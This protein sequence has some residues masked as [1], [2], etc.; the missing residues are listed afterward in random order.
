[1]SSVRV[2][3]RNCAA[4]ARPRHA[5]SPC[6]T[7]TRPRRWSLTGRWSRPS[8]RPDRARSALRCTIGFAQIRAP[9]VETRTGLLP[10]PR[11]RSALGESGRLAIGGGLLAACGRSRSS[12]SG[13]GS[14]PTSASG[15]LERAVSANA[16]RC[17]LVQSGRSGSLVGADSQAAEIPQRQHCWRRR[18]RLPLRPSRRLL[19]S[20][21]STTWQALRR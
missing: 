16:K 8:T 5:L 11:R 4:A 19:T 1:M 6:A 15:L 7:S 9:R 18:R 21:R 2:R 12:A 20:G 13:R 3:R 10:D 14:R 17:P